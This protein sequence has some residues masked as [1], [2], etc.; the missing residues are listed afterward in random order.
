[1]IIPFSLNSSPKVFGSSYY[2]DPII[3]YDP[4]LILFISYY[5]P[6]ILRMKFTQLAFP[7]L[8]LSENSLPL[9]PMGNDHYPY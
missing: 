4:I 3:L 8:G 7:H 5:D 9:H 2:E 1:M 6:M